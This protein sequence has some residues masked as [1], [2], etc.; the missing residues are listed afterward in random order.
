MD[1]NEIQ[2]ALRGAGLDGWLFYDF[3]NRD[4][5]AYR[6]LGMDSTKLTSR[7][8]FYLIPAQGEPRKLAHRVEPTKL[9]LL[10]GRKQMYLSWRE[11]H[12]GLGE[13][14]SGMRRV[15]MQYSPM[16][17][18]PYVSMVD[19]GILELVRATG[20]EVVTSADLVQTFEAVLD[21]EGHRSHLE[22]AE[23]T[24]RIRDEAFAEIG[25]RIRSGKAPT[26]HEIQQFI[27]RRFE[28]EEL[29]C[30]GEYPIVG[31]NEHPANPH[32]EP[33]PQNSHTMKAG[34]T[35]L[36]DL[37]AKLNRPGAI[38]YDIT[39]CGFI[40]RGAIPPKYQRIFNTV[41]DA[42]KAAVEFIRRRFDG[43]E[44]VHGWEVDD[45][46]RKVVT[47][48]GF[49]EYF[50]HRTGHSIGEEVHGNGVNIDN[51][52]TKDERKLVPG[53]C[54]S[55]EPGIY[56]EGEMAARSEINVFITPSGEVTVTGRQQ[57]ELVIVDV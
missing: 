11:L 4:V 40:G 37:W 27:A 1:L 18:I 29:T 45:A 21:E 26:E 28:E 13:M 54:F 16:S 43:G 44:T 52:E 57:E 32:F 20:V 17:N 9:D 50:V 23:R 7:R 2:S 6:I 36:I 8:W 55:I 12:R 39:W 3:H 51:L 10:P 31:V 24:D 47:D 30:C 14:L 35:L 5:L 53:V 33:T 56:L 22:A 42:R 46:C 25:R 34:D 19:A 41:R 15:A 48:A 38:Y 49:G